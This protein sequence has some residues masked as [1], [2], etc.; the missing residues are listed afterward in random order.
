MTMLN[1]FDPKT[2]TEM[3]EKDIKQ[4]E[5]ELAKYDEAI[6]AKQETIQVVNKEIQ[7]LN[8]TIN[9]K[10]T[11]RNQELD[12]LNTLVSQKLKVQ[13]AIEMYQAKLNAE[14]A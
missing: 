13:G 1:I 6:S 10:V 11:R 8:D 7:D 12:E 5:R 9:G 14:Q 4:G 3:L 2:L